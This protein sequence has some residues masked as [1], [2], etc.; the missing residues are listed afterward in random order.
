MALL[1]AQEAR[2][3]QGSLP[4]GGFF[5]DVELPIEQHT[6]IL[7]LLN[8]S[9]NSFLADPRPAP[10]PSTHNPNAKT[11]TPTLDAKT[12][13]AFKQ[14]SNLFYSKFGPNSPKNELRETIIL[15]EGQNPSFKNIEIGPQVRALLGEDAGAAEVL[16]N[17]FDF[18]VGEGKLLGKIRMAESV[19]EELEPGPR[20]AENDAEADSVPSLNVNVIRNQIFT[21]KEPAP[22]RQRV[23]R[24]A[25]YKA[26]LSQVLKEPPGQRKARAPTE[27]ERELDVSAARKLAELTGEPDLGD[28]LAGFDFIGQEEPE[29]LIAGPNANFDDF[30][31]RNFRKAGKYLGKA[32]EPQ[33][34][35][36]ALEGA[37]AQAEPLKNTIKNM[38]LQGI[39]EEEECGD[40]VKSLDQGPEPHYGSR[41]QRGEFTSRGTDE[42][43]FES[44]DSGRVPFIRD[45]NVP[46]QSILLSQNP[47]LSQTFHEP[48]LSTRLMSNHPRLDR[49][50][51][52]G[53]DSFDP[54][55]PG[56]APREAPLGNE[57]QP[58]GFFDSEEVEKDAGGDTTRASD[59]IERFS[60]EKR[61]S[62]K[63][64]VSPLEKKTKFAELVAKKDH[65]MKKYNIKIG[66]RS[67]RETARNS[68]AGSPGAQQ[69][70][71]DNSLGLREGG[72]RKPGAESRGGSPGEKVYPQSLN[73]LEESELRR[74]GAQGLLRKNTFQRFQDAQALGTEH[75]YL[76]GASESDGSEKPEVFSEQSIQTLASID[77]NLKESL[78]VETPGVPNVRQASHVQPGNQ[79][80]R[81]HLREPQRQSSDQLG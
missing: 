42:L 61:V 57:F 68:R 69:S 10:K 60:Q 78:R 25:K 64:P 71:P 31:K 17:S 56:R 49:G 3:S 26:V 53:P 58:K 27:S 39:Q 65:F 77:P 9:S 33:S 52:G 41:G 67:R 73:E 14:G 81:G 66:P 48:G 44:G 8:P 22:P 55:G 19:T 29:P 43:F 36:Q 37:E 59:F 11:L 12:S 18:S 15:K 47:Y 70:A 76:F 75:G 21:K 45:S 40:S 32:F 34:E 79:H 74:G 20:S 13:L 72:G 28:S 54:R 5:A 50:P 24:V 63:A 38:L 4:D 62:P 2:G 35:G 80:V 16:R 7:T 6:Q 1:Q 51:R 23:P 30:L 46:N